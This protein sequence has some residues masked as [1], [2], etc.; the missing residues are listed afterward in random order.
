MKKFILYSIL[1]I[2]FCSGCRAEHKAEKQPPTDIRPPA[3]AGQ[4][5]PSNPSQLELAIAKFLEDA[6]AVP[7]EKPI[8]IIVPHA[9]YIFSGQI[10]ADAFRQAAGH[11]Y[12][13]VVIL[14]TNHTTP[15]FDKVSIYPSGAYR[16]P[17]GS[18]EIDEDV[19]AA[20]IASCDD[21]TFNPSMHNREHSVEVEVPFVQHLFPDAKIIAAVIGSPDPALCAGFGKVL[22]KVL[23]GRSALIVASSD[24]SHYPSF[25]NAV[26]VD[27]E[28]LRAVT[29]LDPGEVRTTI[30]AQMK[31]RIS[32]L[33]TC[34]CGE[35]PILTAITAAKAL[36]ATRGVV[37]SYAN[38]GD[39]AVGDRSRVVGYG[40]VVLTTG[41]GGSDTDALDR[42]GEA[43]RSETLKPADK[44][45]L[46]SFARE[47]IHRYLTTGTVPLAREFNPA[48]QRKQGAFVTLKK[49]GDLR[50][51]IGH[52][53]ADL[54]LCCAVGQSAFNAAFKDHR[55][56]PVGM[57]ELPHLEIEISALTPPRP[58]SGVDDIV[59]GRD[60]VILSKDG[61]SAVYLPKVAVEQ[62]WTKDEM[63]DNLCRKAGLPPGSWRRGAEF[64][65]FQAEVFCESEYKTQ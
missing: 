8:A 60:G 18:V 14:G 26:D 16:T 34:A 33:Q 57:D 58:V 42:S 9:G 27:S 28:V 36:G 7:V 55:F 24:L 29:T 47:T 65:T 20:L 12:D 41:N 51:C 48:V 56:I 13:L 17:L 5:Y 4:F 22:A 54:P 32:H 35:G 15:G 2:A 25:D 38:S 62:D 49:N 21:Y 40:A 63:L 3:V 46:L 53:S 52:M 64:L 1:L 10:A 44:V 59:I 31:R 23:K 30:R 11:E 61:R 19:A 45:A 43:P 39:V 37:V 50:G 6:R